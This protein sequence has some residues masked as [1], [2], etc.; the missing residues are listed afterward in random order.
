MVCV[1]AMVWM[2]VQLDTNIELLSF[3]GDVLAI[4]KT[5]FAII[6]KRMVN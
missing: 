6:D 2:C 1:C 4:L 3:F 5:I